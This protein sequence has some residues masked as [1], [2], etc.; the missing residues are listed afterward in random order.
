[1]PRSRLSC[2]VKHVK[3]WSCE[4]SSEGLWRILKM[5]LWIR[6]DPERAE[7]WSSPVNMCQLG[8]K[9]WDHVITHNCH[10]AVI[11]LLIIITVYSR[12]AYTRLR[13][14]VC[15]SLVAVAKKLMREVV[16]F[17]LLLLDCDYLKMLT[18][19]CRLWIVLFSVV[20]LVLQLMFQSSLDIKNMPCHLWPQ[21]GTVSTSDKCI[22]PK[23]WGDRKHNDRENTKK[24][25]LY[26]R[27]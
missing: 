9:H 10:H 17:F 14:T 5:N 19:F 12:A 20:W 6:T 3:E 26:C 18:V 15:W 13:S 11:T 1:M 21:E 16:F 27:M 7:A 4:E 23:K 25:K 24:K 22:L 8:N 2:C